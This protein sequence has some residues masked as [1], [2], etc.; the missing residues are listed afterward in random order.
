MKVNLPVDYQPTGF[1]VCIAYEKRPDATVQQTT[2]ENEKR[3][4]KEE[5]K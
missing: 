1:T 3:R 5:K 4:K 2:K